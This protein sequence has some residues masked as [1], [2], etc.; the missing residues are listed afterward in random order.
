MRPCRRHAADTGPSW[1][2][3]C[4]DSWATRCWFWLSLATSAS[5][6][7]RSASLRRTAR[8][9]RALSASLVS[10]C[11]Q[12][13]LRVFGPGRRVAVAG[14]MQ[15]ALLLPGGGGCPCSARAACPQKCVSRVFRGWEAIRAG[16][17]TTRRRE[18]VQCVSPTSATCGWHR[19]RGSR[20]CIC[21]RTPVRVVRGETTNSLQR[22]ST[23]GVNA[24]VVFLELKHL[25]HHTSPP[26]SQRHP[27]SSQR[28]PASS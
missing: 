7:S 15:T 17:A 3:S 23:R 5:L 22:A 2:E 27:A 21:P 20:A 8:T 12:P 13:R 10:W 16:R 6:R 28:H 1:L 24:L 4:S 26:S 14:E 11:S 19:F 25:P 18:V 9:R